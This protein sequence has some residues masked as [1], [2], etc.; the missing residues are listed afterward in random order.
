[1]ATNE[2][3]RLAVADDEKKLVGVVS[4]TDLALKA[5]EKMAKEIMT[6]LKKNTS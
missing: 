1:M 5:D 2:V 3:R 6:I 4:L